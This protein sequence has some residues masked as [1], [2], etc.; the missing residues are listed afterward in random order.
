MLC[1]LCMTIVLQSRDF[2]V[3]FPGPHGECATSN[4][5]MFKHSIICLIRRKWRW[6]RS[7]SSSIS[8]LMERGAAFNSFD[9]SRFNLNTSCSQAKWQVNRCVC[10]CVCCCH[11][12]E[13]QRCGNN[14]RR[15]SVFYIFLQPKRAAHKSVW[16]GPICQ[17]ID[18]SMQAKTENRSW[19][20]DALAT[21]H[22]IAH[23]L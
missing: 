6:Q 12:P 21:Q 8:S 22:L 1:V 20:I 3:R 23:R 14:S 19:S 10:V 18:R 2:I 11:T 7:S 13:L 9:R 5:C 4:C 16:P 17:S 15:E